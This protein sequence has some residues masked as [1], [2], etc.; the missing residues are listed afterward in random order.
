MYGAKILVLPHTLKNGKL[1][2]VYFSH[3][4]LPTKAFTQRKQ[5]VSFLLKTHMY[6][7]KQPVLKHNYHSN[8]N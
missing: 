5:N 1:L 8:S 7:P 2:C 4:H 3:E 6:N